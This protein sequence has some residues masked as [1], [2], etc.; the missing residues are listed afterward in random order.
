M[1][2][3]SVLCKLQTYFRGC[4]G[5]QPRTDPGFVTE[6]HVCR[7]QG[8]NAT[9]C[10]IL[11]FFQSKSPQILESFP[12]CP[13]CRPLHA[14]A[15]WLPEPELSA[16]V[17]QVLAKASSPGAKPDPGFEKHACRCQ[18]LNAAMC[19]IVEFFPNPL[20]FSNIS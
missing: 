8:L 3:K 18:G 19:V 5:A 16:R 6:K 15:G 1:S 20:R 12:R 4:S 9:M 17:N 7:C 10:V 14:D 11:E 13:R 2:R